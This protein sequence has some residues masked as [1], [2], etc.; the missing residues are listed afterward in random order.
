M[1][2]KKIGTVVFR[3]NLSPILA[4]FRLVP[5]DG[6]N[7]PEYRA[8]Q[9][10]ALR[11]EDCRLTR[12]VVRGDGSIVYV[13]DL[14][15]HGN[16]R[17][18]AVSHSYSIASAPYETQIRRYLEFYVILHLD[19]KG[20]PGRFTESLFHTDPDGDN[21][22][23]YFFKIAGE[24]TLDKH[25]DGFSHVVMV[26][27]GSGLAPFASMMKQ[28]HFD[29]QNG[30]TS[31]VRYTL[32][33]GNRGYH[34]LGYHDDLIAIEASERLDFVYV[35]TISRPSRDDRDPLTVGK[36]RA[37]NVLRYIMGMPSKEEE[38]LQREQSAGADTAHAEAMLARLVH[39]V[40]P[41]HIQRECIRER[42]QSGNT[43]IITCGNP[44][45]MADIRHI[46]GSQGIDFDMEEW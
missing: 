3:R 40:L 35:P 28:V 36:G 27:T 46:A 2:D 13:P 43:I 33:H 15:E 4:I 41:H 18:G 30:K 38:D 26:G 37:N 8:G 42:I 39:P 24:F 16:Q 34:E 32:I 1:A 22:I 5:E 45:V 19:D 9:Y 10:I 44:E 20:Q 25:T 23:T 7:F 29:A 11:R 14:D 21:T 31:D 17:R 6:V 12:K